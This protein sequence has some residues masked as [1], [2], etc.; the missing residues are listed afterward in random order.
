MLWNARYRKYAPAIICSVS[1]VIVCLLYWVALEWNINSL[2]RLENLSKDSRAS[3]GTKTERY[4]KLIYVAID[5]LT[6]SLSAASP[7]EIAASPA[8]TMMQRGWPFPR[9]VYPLILDKLFGA[10]AKLVIFDLLFFPPKPEDAVFRQSLDKYRG[11]VVL[12]WNLVFDGGARGRIY[13]TIQ[14]PGSPLIDQKETEMDLSL[15]Y[16]NYPTDSDGTVRKAQFR[17][18]LS[19]YT[20]PVESLPARVVTLLGKAD[21]IPADTDIHYFRW[22]GLN[23]FYDSEAGFPSHSLWELFVPQLWKAN[24]QNGEMFRDAVVMVGPK[25]NYLKDEL[26]TPLGVMPGPEVHLNVIN[27]LLKGAYIHETPKF[28][29]I[30][31]IALAGALA[32]LIL[33]HVKSPVWIFAYLTGVSLIYIGLGFLLYNVASLYILISFPLFCFTSSGLIGFTNEFVAEQIERR[34]TRATLERYVSK[35]LVREI[36][37]NPETF[38]N[39]VGGVRLPVTA[40]F[41]DVR[42]FTTMTERADPTQMVS[43]LNE[44]L[45]EMTRIVFQYGGTLDKFVGDAVMAVWGN[46]RTVGTAQDADNAVRTALAMLESLRQLNER[47]RSRGMPTWV[48]GVGINQ[49]EAIAGNIGSNEKMDLTVIGDAVNTASRLE[50]LT[51]KYHVPLL[52]GP[53]VAAQV[54]ERFYLQSVDRAAAKGKSNA[55]DL[56]TVLGEKAQPLS[57]EWLAYLECYEEGVR[58]FR[59]KNFIEALEMFESL[60][61]YRPDDYLANL[62]IERCRKYIAEPPEANWNG[63]VIITEK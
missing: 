26:V 3:N 50:G 34:R 42:D 58:L 2:L 11:K 35:N 33:C 59:I 1:T 62:Y 29:D 4:P 60:L 18:H 57:K 22:V 31:C 43:Q 63:V 7:E 15:G 49:G 30:I 25:G 24:Y 16:V 17:G 53:T 32:C 46:I 37:D 19:P 27:A 5:D 39:K 40:L 12:G 6:I 55:L 51:K 41:S 10:G 52:I 47:W 23:A 28:I 8:L 20:Q 36:L 14:L 13:N 21:K 61:P 9:T 38:Y 44:Y 45:Q 48:I 54:R 56:Y